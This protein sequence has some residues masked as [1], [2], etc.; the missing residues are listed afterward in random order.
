MAVPGRA[1]SAVT[2]REGRMHGE[3]VSR[4][5]Q[6]RRSS[7]PIH[8]KRRPIAVDAS[9]V[10]GRLSDMVAQTYYLFLGGQP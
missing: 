4:G 8:T 5:C 10:G 1:V 7:A 9:L 3:G 6:M 2:R